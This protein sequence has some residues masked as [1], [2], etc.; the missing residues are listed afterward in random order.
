MRKEFPRAIRRSANMIPVSRR[1]MLVLAALACLQPG[2]TR[3]QLS[4]G[5]P[6]GSSG[7][8]RIATGQFDNLNTV[9][10]GGGSSTYLSYLWGAYLFLADDRGALQPELAT[11]IPTIQNGGISKDGLTITYHLRHGVRW[12]DG[13]PFDARDMVFTWHAIMNPKNNVVTRL[14]Y[15]K[16]ASMTAVDPYTVRVRL[17]E[18]FAPAVATLF[19][20]GEVPMPILPQHLLGSLP[21]INH[22]A[23]NNLPVGTGAF[24]IQRYDPST[25]VTLVA[26]RNYWRGTPKLHGIEYLIIPDTN[27]VMVMLRSNE[28]DVANVRGEHA[29]ELAHAPGVRIVSEAAPEDLYLAF[30]LTHPPLDDVRVRRAIAMAVDRKFFLQAFQYSTGSVAESDQPPYLPFY[31]P[32]VRAPAY[33]PAQAQRLLEEAGWHRDATGYRSKEGKRLALTFAYIAARSPD[34]KFA[35]IFQDTMKSIG[36]ALAVKA[37]PYNLYYAQ[38]AEGGVLNG[39]KY[40]IAIT[41]WVLGSDPDDATLW[42]CDQRPPEGYNT[43]FLCDPRVDAAERLAL[44]TYDFRA[45]RDAYWKIQ[46]LLAQDVPAVFLTWVNTIFAVRDSVSDFKPGE[47]LWNSWNWAKN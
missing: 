10:S 26:N 30:N 38:K 45:R 19:G 40:D 5:N 23:Y 8:L 12:H 34:T 29:V 14:G 11:D 20:P 39:G 25:G 7:I 43:S 16:V 15:E 9:L 44:S 32:N 13:V 33:D 24:V 35:P 1:L 3:V 37:Y 17:K 36:I 27:T 47:N 2:C 21:D 28:V 31:D 6:G 18:R 41:G 42:M 22:A 4:H 46:E